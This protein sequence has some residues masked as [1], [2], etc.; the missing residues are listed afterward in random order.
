MSRV[1]QLAG[2]FLFRQGL[3]QALTLVV[4]LLLLRVLPMEQYAL[5]TIAGLLLTVVSLG[6]DFGLGQAIVSLG[7]GRRD[8]RSYIGALWQAARRISAR[9]FPLTA[10]VVLGGAIRMFHG[11]AWPLHTQA[12]CVVLV[13]SIGL[14]QINTSLGRSVFNMHHDVS[15]IFYTGGVEALTRLVLVVA[16]MAWPFAVTALTAN[17]VGATAASIVATRR[18]RSLLDVRAAPNATHRDALSSFVM[19]IV[20]MAIYT[21]LQGQIAIFML[22]VGGYTHAIAEVGALSRLSQAFTVLMMLNPFLVQPVFARIASDRDFQAKL[23]PVVAALIVLCAVGLTSAYAAPQW[24]LFLLG[25]NYAGLAQE[26]PI[27][28]GTALMT[29]VGGTLYTVVIARGETR[30]QSLW[31]LPCLVG[32][33]AFIG[34]HGVQNTRDA[35]L[36][37]AI[38]A[39][40]IC[41]VECLLLA[42]CV[43]RI[44]IPLACAAGKN[45]PP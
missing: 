42:K 45:M 5:Y 29:V 2:T 17:L 21:L 11:Q 39:A 28:I 3:V 13:L 32:Q 12:A 22:S 38:P 1:A 25:A 15:A 37:N 43:R 10:L 35:L 34:F 19:P 30:G 41:F 4:G 7:A 6:S 23:A 33:V 31:V 36:L 9:L 8:D 40:A 44:P 24:W 14:V 20:P 26:L 27:T 16:C 18:T